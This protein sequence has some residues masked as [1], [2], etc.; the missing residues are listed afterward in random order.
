MMNKL[1]MP[2]N[3]HT[4]LKIFCNTCKKDNSNCSHY[5]MHQYRVRIHVPNT[6][7]KVKIKTLETRDY[8]EAVKQ[9]IDFKKELI[10]NGFEHFK[11]TVEGNDYSLL[12]AIIKYNQYLG[13]NHPLEQKK[14][15]VTKE[16]Q[17]E[18][19]RFC[20]LF[21]EVVK[22]RADISRLRIVDITKHDVS[23]FYKWAKEHY[24]PKTFNKCLVSLKAFFKFL[25][26]DEEVKMKNPFESYVSRKS[27]PKDILILTKAEFELIL[28]GLNTANP[29]KQLGGR[30]ERKNM[31]RPYLEAGFKLMLFTGGRR[32]EVVELR[33]SDIFITI[34]GA[35]CFRIR[36]RKVERGQNV[37]GIYKYIPINADLL[38]LLEDL[39]YSDKANSNDYIF[40]PER[41]EK[42]KTIMDFLSKSFSHY[43][44]AVGI[45]KTIS[46]KNLRKTYISWV[47]DVMG[48]K[49][50]LLTSHSSYKVL[51]SHYLDPSLITAIDRGA[52]EIRIF[53]T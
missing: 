49:T 34:K 43:K 15:I 16:H 21:A 11:P 31:F 35:K 14:K 36:N 29:I 7:H 3:P 2:K 22:G 51:T 12:D 18:C 9:A 27:A 13:G 24:S 28:N 53:G 42:T 47:H 40:Y 44:E 39:G 1:R 48:E 26:D 38:Y 52:Q 17:A 10:V 50:G 46:M 4:G 45:E 30:G 25:I 33:W 8:D 5:D 19:I 41:A 20:S 23:D 37:Q 6:K 32:E